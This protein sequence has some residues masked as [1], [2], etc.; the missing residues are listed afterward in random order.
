MLLSEP[1]SYPENHEPVKAG[2]L[3]SGS[4]GKVIPAGGAYK[5]LDPFRSWG[6]VACGLAGVRT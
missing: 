4:K 1:L 6:I 2:G 3:S 5:N